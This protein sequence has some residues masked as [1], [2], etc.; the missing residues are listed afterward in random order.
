MEFKSKCRGNNYHTPLTLADYEFLPKY[1]KTT[2]SDRRR[3][4]SYTSSVFIVESYFFISFVTLE[5]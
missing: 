1:Y 2:H 4:I 5:T 3:N